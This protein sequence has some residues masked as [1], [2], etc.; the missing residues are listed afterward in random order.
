MLRRLRRG[1]TRYAAAANGQKM[2]AASRHLCYHVPHK[3]VTS[4]AAEP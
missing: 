4:D 3:A 1:G 2:A